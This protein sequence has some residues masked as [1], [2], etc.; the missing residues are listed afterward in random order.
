M[1]GLLFPSLILVAQKR[2]VVVG[3]RTKDIVPDADG[4]IDFSA[5]QEPGAP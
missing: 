3:M 2:D 5:K 4:I 1:P